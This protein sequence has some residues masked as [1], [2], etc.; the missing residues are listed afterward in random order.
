MEHHHLS[1]WLGYVE[2]CICSWSLPA[3][4]VTL[5]QVNT[6]VNVSDP[7]WPFVTRACFITQGNNMS[8]VLCVFPC[9]NEE[10]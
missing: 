8:V 7:L 1:N 4:P 3:L 2:I 5:I 6:S 10:V 9:Q